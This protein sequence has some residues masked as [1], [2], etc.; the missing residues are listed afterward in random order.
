LDRPHLA[1]DESV[2]TRADIPSV[3]GRC[4]LINIKL[5]KCGGLTEA[6]AM[7]RLAR[8]LG[9]G[10]MVGNMM[11]TSLGMAPSF[12]LGQLCEVVDLDGP[13]LLRSDR[14]VAVDYVDGYIRCPE[15][16][17]GYPTG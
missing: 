10:N 17:W 12:L 3:A 8:Q 5:D 16:L 7:A 11:S 15:G 14:D 13:A 1:A 2:Q 4:Q 9:L 6:F